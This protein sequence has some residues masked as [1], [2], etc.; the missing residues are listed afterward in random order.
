MHLCN[1]KQYWRIMKVLMDE[2]EFE[3]EIC[4]NNDESL[5]SYWV[6]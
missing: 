1:R 4:N 2:Y 3:I 6:G 5:L